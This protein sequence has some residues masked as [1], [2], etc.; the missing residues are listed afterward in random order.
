[1]TFSLDIAALSKAYAEG[2]VTPE[3]VIADVYARIAA[4]GEKP[5]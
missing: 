1:M 5:V 4:Y 2:A 3:A